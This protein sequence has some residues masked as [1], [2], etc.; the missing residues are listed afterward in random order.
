MDA[1]IG[2]PLRG[3]RST[4]SRMK[5]V[6]R[7]AAAFQD[8]TGGRTPGRRAG[9]PVA[10]RSDL[11]GLRAVAVLAVSADHLFDWPPSGFVGVDVFFVLSGFFITALLIRER[12]TKHK[13]SFR[14]FYVR[15]IK[16]ILP[17]ALLVLG[18][19]VA[20]AYLLFSAVRAKQTLLD[21]LYAALFAANF[22][23]EAVGADYFQRGQ[24]PSPLQHY[25]SLSIEEQFYFVWPA[26]LVVIFALTRRLRS[27]RKPWARQWGLIGAMG[28]VVG[29]SFAWAMVLSSDDP[30]RAYF[31]TFTRVW[32]LGIGALMAIAGP[33]LARIPSVIRP[34]L[35][36]LGLAGLLAS[37]FVIDATVGFPAPWAA[38]PVLST[39]LVIAS[40]H[41]AE[42]RGMYPLINPVARW[43]GDTSYTLYLWH[44]PVFTLLLTVMPRGPRYD[45]IALA[46]AVGLTAIT[47]HFYED[48]IRKSDWLL[49]TATPRDGRLPRLSRPGWAV[50]GVLMVAVLVL[51]IVDIRYDELSAPAAGTV[52]PCFGAPAMRD[53][54]CV[55]WNPDLP[56]Q[57]SIDTFTSD[58]PATPA[59]QKQLRT[60]ERCF[61]LE[62][63]R[64]KSCTYGYMGKDATRI[65]LVGDSHGGAIL[66]AL[67]PL[68][69]KNRWQLTTYVG[70]SCQWI[71][72]TRA[73]CIGGD[74]IEP[75]LLAGR[76]DLVLTTAWRGSGST[77]ADYQKAWVPVAAA[78]GRIAVIAAIPGVSEESL[79]CLTRVSF[80]VDRTGDCGTSRMEAFAQPES[81]I[82][83]ARL[84]PGASV[85]D[86]TPY[87]CNDVRCPSV[88]GNVIVYRDTYGHLTATF[89]RTLAPAVEVGI[90]R[91][92]GA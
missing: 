19:T 91:A 52:G 6:G 54:H 7:P 62:D 51:S 11:Q 20:A 75:D 9:D 18:A 76:Y 42:V 67:L 1:A 13:L 29:T 74:A 78:G 10:R 34:G 35:A 43:F 60:S 38:L 44:W 4:V 26:L 49:D 40:F 12:A 88:I 82:A 72:P 33:W 22:H 64:L 17:S 58:S 73:D 15:R 68:L 86:L 27:S 48:P 14:D 56:L 39:A 70:I 90:R 28:V 3:A 69:V 31:S 83:A 24:S 30:N 21:G 92:L 79:A 77:A 87:Y 65:A 63:M 47:Y 84:V 23:F 46:L 80:G 41:G 36:Y 61:R 32:E 25:W 57:P 81:L 55:L 16:R 5:A 66:P 71:S 50:S 8:Q 85:I 59:D 2:P 89:A 45:A 37:L 53:G